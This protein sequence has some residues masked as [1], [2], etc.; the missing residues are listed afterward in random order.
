MAK[1]KVTSTKCPNCNTSGTFKPSIAKGFTS[2]SE[3][4]FVYVE[5]RKTKS[6]ATRSLGLNNLN[7]ED[8]I[9]KLEG[10]K[11]LVPEGGVTKIVSERNYSYS[12]SSSSSTYKLKIEKEE[13]DEELYLRMVEAEK[14][15]IKAEEKRRKEAEKKA[16]AARKKQESK[17]RQR[18]IKEKQEEKK[19]KDREKL[20]LFL[21]NNGLSIDS[22]KEV[23]L[24]K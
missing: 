14:K 18:K 24:S 13:G 16:E 6:V 4:H 20:E 1:K 5:K 19:R 23:L 22:V 21:K 17:D 10:F 7:L 8:A 3:C 2:C 9:K 11:K 15:A 12:Y